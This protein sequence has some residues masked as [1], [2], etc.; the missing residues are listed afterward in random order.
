MRTSFLPATDEALRAWAQN[1]ATRTTAD[2]AL[3]GL[4]AGEAATFAGLSAAYSAALTEATEPA[5]RTRGTV[6]AKDDART[7]LRREASAL[8]KKVQGTVT[9]TNQQKIDL[10]LN[11]PDVIPSPVPP[12]ATAPLLSV[13]S[14]A[15][16]TVTLRMRDALN[17][18]RRAKPAGVRS[19]TV[20]SFVGPMAPTELGQWKFEGNTTRTTLD[21]VFGPAAEPGALVWLT[22]FWS[23][24]RAESGPLGSPI[25]TH[26]QFGGVAMAA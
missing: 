17:P 25:S 7:E 20:F 18:D 12:P 9:V 4:S 5:T 19:A 13:K 24:G 16:R 6:A 26:L 1:F 22:A 3:Y 14:V 23:N 8:S 21:V 2:A 11:V 15:G 10:G